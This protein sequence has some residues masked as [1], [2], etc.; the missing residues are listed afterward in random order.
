MSARSIINDAIGE[1][2]T[3]TIEAIFVGP[4]GQPI[5]DPG[6]VTGVTLLKLVHLET[7]EVVNG[8]ANVNVLADMGGLVG[9]A[10]AFSFVL[11]AADTVGIGTAKLQERVATLRVT[12]TTGVEQHDIH[13]FV[14]NLV[15]V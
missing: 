2:S 12:Y 4:N 11:S 14:E 6:T 13:F 8:R 5:A 15:G 3:R 10:G 1:G 9:A 7:S